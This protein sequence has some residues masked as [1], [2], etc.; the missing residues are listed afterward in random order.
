[1]GCFLHQC[2][3]RVT[4]KDMGALHVLSI[5]NGIVNHTEFTSVGQI[6]LET[7][8]LGHDLNAL[9]HGLRRR[10]TL[11]KSMPQAVQPDP[12]LE[13][14]ERTSLATVQVGTE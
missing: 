1:M 9:D 12:H 13:E 7:C 10:L 5:K 3:G 8:P 4:H 2:F 11:N 6:D 14:N